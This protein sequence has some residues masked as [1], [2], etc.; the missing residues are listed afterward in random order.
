MPDL[1]STA[2]LLLAGLAGGIANAVAGGGTLITFPA[3][4][5]VG[6]PPVI[7]NASNAVAVTPGHLIA[8]IADREKLPPMDGTMVRILLAGLVGGSL[9]AVLLTL[10][11][12]KLFGLLVP[13]LIGIATGIFAFSRQI[14]RFI[15]RFRESHTQDSP[16]GR[17]P[18][19]GAVTVYGGYFGAGQGIMLMAALAVT[20]HED[21]RVH[22]A[23]KNLLSA[24]VGLAGA[25]I[26]IARGMASPVETALV[27]AGGLIGGYAGG[28]LVKVLPQSLIRTTVIGVGTGLTV[29]YAWRNWL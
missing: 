11:S 9:G 21:V 14:Q 10:S 27:M 23:I 25:A 16:A 13:A 28:R 26:F 5:A 6:L 29:F 1:A 15:A 17:L 12:E 8:A 20:G 19:L 24:V 4:V 18:I 22:N 7:A 2:L 3:L